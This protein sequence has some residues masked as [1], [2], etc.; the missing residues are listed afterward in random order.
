M[1]KKEENDTLNKLMKILENLMILECLHRSKVVSFSRFFLMISL[2]D[3]GNL[4]SGSS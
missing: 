1:N 3:T 2:R 4:G